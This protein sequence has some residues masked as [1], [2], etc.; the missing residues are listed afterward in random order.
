MS[1]SFSKEERVAFEDI[2]QG[3]EDALVLSRNVSI[4]RTEDQMME[5]ANDTIWRPMPYIA[6][7]FDGTDMTSNFVDSTQLSV[8]ASLG[9]SKSSPWIMTAKELRDKLQEGRLGD[10]AKQKL[11]SDVNVAI[12]S[13]ACLQG[14]LVVD[15]STAATGFD[16]IAEA[17]AA[18]NEIGVQQFDRYAA[19]S[20]RDYNNMASNLADRGTVQGKV[21]TAYEK[22]RIGTLASFETYKLDYANRLT[23]G[24]A[25]TISV[26]GANQ[27][28]TPAATSTAGTGETSNV[29]NRYQTLAITA[30]GTLAA[31][32]CFTIAGVN[33]VHMITKQ[34]T[35][36]LK[37]FRVITGG[38]TG[39]IVISP[40][41]ISG[42][43][44]T[45]AEL[46]YQ[47]VTA[48]P[49]DTAVITLLNVAD[50][51]MNPFWQMDALEIL[52]GRYA[53]PTDAG[54]AVMRATTD[55]GLDLVWQKFYDINTMNIKYR[56]DILFGVVCKQPE[57]AGIMLFGQ[58]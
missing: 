29:D 39:D 31:G 26:N 48:T 25:T 58:T 13:V 14:T 55:Q 35:G 18:M 52:P 19:L 11:A 2:C 3:F 57:M 49:I 54:A 46:Q 5:R 53:V 4:Y 1:N 9:Y 10:A 12:M 21:L 7:S 51:Y 50:A 47:N 45:D 22:A 16:D 30:T 44:G 38:G 20:T 34:D 33:S 6:Q 37:T 8:P 27:Y 24:T 41:I 17:E 42:D 43:G 23:A 28:Y 36:Q 56:L 15:V 40:P 32:D